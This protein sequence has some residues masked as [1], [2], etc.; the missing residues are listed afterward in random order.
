MFT[1]ALAFNSKTNQIFINKE[2][3]VLLGLRMKDCATIKIWYSSLLKTFVLWYLKFFKAIYIVYNIFRNVK[4][5]LA[6]HSNNYKLGDKG[7]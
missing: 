1:S 2:L 4:K 6:S 7:Q 5:I 3:N